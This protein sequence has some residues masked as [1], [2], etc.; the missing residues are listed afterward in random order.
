MDNQTHKFTK[1]SYDEELRK[2]MLQEYDEFKKSFLL[3]FEE[4]EQEKI[5]CFLDDAVEMLDETDIHVYPDLLW[6]ELFTKEAQK[7]GTFVYQKFIS[8][9]K[10]KLWDKKIVAPALMIV[11]CRD[12]NAFDMSDYAEINKLFSSHF[13]NED[14]K[15]FVDFK[16]DKDAKKTTYHIIYHEEEVKPLTTDEIL[17]IAYHSDENG[18][19]PAL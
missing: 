1:Y 5:R 3:H 10:L 7:S 6:N 12:K 2:K 4:G 8:L 9:K 17:S 14:G 15:S 18:R 16:V 19:Y 13:E 11:K